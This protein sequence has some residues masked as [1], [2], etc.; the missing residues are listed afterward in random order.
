MRVLIVGATG[1]I[2]RQL[3][4]LLAAGGHDV[5]GMSRS[6]SRTD[7]LRKSGAA[8]VITG[9]LNAAAMTRAVQEAEPDAIVNLL[10]AVPN[11]LD[12][13]HFARDLAAT[14]L[15]RTR[16]TRNLVAAAESAGVE[17]IVCGGIAYAYDPHGEGPAGE[18]TSLWRNPPKQFV[19][20]RDALL[21]MEQRTRRAG[22]LV[23]RFGHLYGPGTHYAG[24]GSFTKQVRDGKVPLVGGGDATF[25]F[26]HTEDAATAILAALEQRARGTLNIVDDDPAPMREWLPFLAQILDARKPKPMPS[27]LARLAVGGWGVAFMTQLRGADN[28]RARRSL[29]WRPRYW[30]WRDGFTAELTQS[31]PGREAA[32]RSPAGGHGQR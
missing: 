25:S 13:K 5:V 27:W 17:L 30:S 14:N 19:P 10:T 31:T 9:A 15:L 7:A 4:P 18:D 6:S 21:E 20:S 32:Q 16:G 12:P 8:V 22:G 2:G 26:T 24:S 3:V 23:L 1:V 11:E 28:A 29:D